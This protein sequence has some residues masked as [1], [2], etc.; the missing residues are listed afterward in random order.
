MIKNK[1]FEKINDL[2][3]EKK[4]FL[5]DGNENFDKYYQNCNIY[6]SLSKREG[7]SQSMIKSM[8]NSNIIISL[9]VAGCRNLIQNNING[10]L[11]DE[12]DLEKK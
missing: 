6:L 1:Y 4:V 10:F 12:K 2:L 5:V 11:I 8:H 3:T 7:L 9:N